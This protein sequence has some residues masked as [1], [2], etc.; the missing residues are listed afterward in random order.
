MRKRY[1]EK[2]EAICKASITL[3]NSRGLVNT[4][5]VLIAKRA[6][7][8]PAT[9]YIDFKNKQDLL[10]PLYLR[11]QCDARGHIFTGYEGFLP[12]DESFKILL[13][14]AYQYFFGKPE[15]FAFLN[16]FTFYQS[17]NWSNFIKM[18]SLD[19]STVSLKLH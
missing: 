2:E 19:W 15:Y 9:I 5:M 1:S 17:C 10:R 14:K 7:V 4:S 12:L 18:A 3:I 8:S 16:Q 6:K 11:I 13:R